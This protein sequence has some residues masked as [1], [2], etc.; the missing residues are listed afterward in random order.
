MDIIVQSLM[1]PFIIF[2]SVTAIWIICSLLENT[3]NKE[4]NFLT[5]KL[6]PLQILCRLCFMATLIM[7]FYVVVPIDGIEG[8]PYLAIVA[9]NYVIALAEYLAITFAYKI[10]T[11]IV[12][13]ILWIFKR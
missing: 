2:L 8:C 1:T 13:V 12:L 5:F 7:P 9:L 6:H 11:F 3:F 4:Q 10:L